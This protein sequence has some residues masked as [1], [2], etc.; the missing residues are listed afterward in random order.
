MGFDASLVLLD[1][2]TRLA[3]L[4]TTLILAATVA[5]ALAGCQAAWADDSPY[6]Y[7][8]HDEGGEHL[9]LDRG[10]TGY[11]VL[12]E[13]IGDDPANGSGRD[14]R[15]LRDRGATPV[16]RLDLGFGPVS[17]TLPTPDRYPAFAAR[18]ARFV[19]A[20]PGCDIWIVG[21]E[22]NMAAWR[23]GG[24]TGPPI[25]P[26]D[27]ERAFRLCRQAIRAVPG[28]GADRV[29]VQ[30]TAP[31]NAETGYWLDYHEEVLRR[32]GPLGCDGLAVH[33]YTHG[34]E[35]WRI[36]RDELAPGGAGPVW[37]Q[38]PDAHFDFLSYRDF[39]RRVP[40]SMRHLPVWCTETNPDRPWID[41]DTGW[42]REAYA[43]V[44]RWNR[45]P[46]TQKLRCLA[47]Y[48]WRNWDD[49]GMESK[50]GV[51]QDFVAAVDRRY[52]WD[53]AAA[54]ASP[55][56]P[57]GTLR[58]DFEPGG[59]AA[60]R[61]TFPYRRRVAMWTAGPADGV[62]GARGRAFVLG[63]RATFP[64]AHA[65]AMAA[66]VSTRLGAQSRLRYRIR[67]EGAGN[68]AVDLVLADGTALRDLDL[69]G[70]FRDARGIDVHPAAQ[71]HPLG[72]WEDVEVDLS[73]AAGREVRQV[74]VAFDA[75]SSGWRGAFRV[76]V[77][78]VRIGR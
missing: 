50:R 32:I 15:R 4:A 14:L 16:V 38:F 53:R 75:G 71:R 49:R 34:P 46:G 55:A 45:T 19:A 78:E 58:L 39:L 42:V 25:T 47:L 44:D 66:R 20:S 72:A 6:I 36:T 8:L 54:P 33:T 11:V 37:P 70:R 67:C 59:V 23:P 27:Y 22:T 76:A 51:Q 69:G 9:F 74:L 52:R 41:A 73:R 63:G 17:G 3:R 68:S 13:G 56:P 21:N 64:G 61:D 35:T 43:E 18:A 24:R 12:A 28:H 10:V 29:V 1:A 60:P 57:A 62:P 31:W 7:G 26:A 2:V 30:A 65:Y 5:N 48:R 77:D 40:P